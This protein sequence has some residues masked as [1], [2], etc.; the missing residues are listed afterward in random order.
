[1]LA[2]R[3]AREL[4]AAE[5]EHIGDYLLSQQ[6]AYQRLQAREQLEDS[7]AARAW[8][9]TLCG[10][11]DPLAAEPLPEIPQ[12]AR[13]AAAHGGGAQPSAASAAASARARPAAQRA[14]KSSSRLGGALLLGAILAA[15]VVAA[16][17][18]SGGSGSS[19][20]AASSQTGTSAAGQP[21]V[22]KQLRLA[23]PDPSSN[24]IG[25]VEVVSQAGKQAFFIAAE[26][27]PPSNGFFYAAWLYNSPSDHQILGRAPNVT[28]NGRLQ[29]LALLPTNA[30]HF[31][32]MIVTRETS[33]KPSNPGPIVLQGPFSLH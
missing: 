27:L 14:P 28:A 24:A 20:K 12:P 17:L 7:A 11:L 31:H 16:V 5:R 15:I 23:S 3:Q 32:Q 30:S 33:E 13:D 19:H 9:Q 8:A 6:S 29:A 18:L 25:V 1:V 10:E 4:S 26:H 22:D 21:H 2:P